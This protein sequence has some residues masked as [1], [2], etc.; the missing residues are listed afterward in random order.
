M[1]NCSQSDHSDMIY[2][3]KNT[4]EYRSYVIKKLINK[5]VQIIHKKLQIKYLIY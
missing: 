2:V 4:D 3:K 5:S 1:F